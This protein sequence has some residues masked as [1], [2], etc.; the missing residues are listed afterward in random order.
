M[1][2]R[3]ELIAEQLMEANINRQTW[4]DLLKNVRNYDTLQEAFDAAM[5]ANADVG[6]PPGTDYVTTTP[7]VA[8]GI[9]VL[10][11][12]DVLITNYSGNV[13]ATP[14]QLIFEN[15]KV[16]DTGKKRLKNNTEFNLY[17]AVIR[18]HFG[19]QKGQWYVANEGTGIRSYTLSSAAAAGAKTINLSSTTGLLATQLIC[20]L[21]TD[22]EY[23][24][25][26]VDTVSAGSINV[27][28]GLD[29]GIAAGVN[30]WAFYNNFSH[31]NLYGYRTLADFALRS[32][33][34]DGLNEQ[35]VAASFRNLYAR[36]ADLVDAVGTATFATNTSS[37]AVIPGSPIMN[38]LQVNCAASG[39]GFKTKP[40][41]LSGK[42]YKYKIMMNAGSTGSIIITVV[43][44]TGLTIASKTFASGGSYVQF[45]EDTFK[46]R[47]NEEVQVQIIQT[48][49]VS[50][51]QVGYIDIIELGEYK[52]NLNDGTH[53]LLG[54]SWFYDEGIFQRLNERLPNSVII[55]SGIGGNRVEDLI[56]RFDTAVVPYKPDYV[57]IMC[58]TNDYF[59]SVAYYTFAAQMDILLAKI[60][61]IGAKAICFEPSVGVK[62][63]SG[64]ADYQLTD[65]SRNYLFYTE[66]LQKEDG[67]RELTGPY[68]FDTNT[69][70]S[71]LSAG[72]TSN[73]ACFGSFPSGTQ[74]EIEN[75]GGI[76]LSASVYIEV[77]FISTINGGTFDQSIKITSDSNGRL[78]TILTSTAS[79][80]VVVRRQNAS[81]SADTFGGSLRIRVT[82]P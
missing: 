66:Y 49:T 14:E 62:T 58:G 33:R 65:L 53:V 56:N 40:F 48:G 16:D 82:K 74:L 30:L 1:T 60:A 25:A 47:F 55:N 37:N 71:T 54:D 50:F 15:I 44:K 4:G 9:R 11:F 51:M 35:K 39:D 31:P 3:A 68:V 67:I 78:S 2:T 72:A 13:F 69:G 42:S 81:A 19:A 6:F 77:G 64:Y 73:E 27:L 45:V 22:G 57:W 63:Y 38:T 26:Q 43:T 61:D 76:F 28:A 59:G 79:R 8:S 41:K 70:L 24:S 10:G 80:Y 32:L 36:R 75:C 21:G 23:Y 46:S 5:A 29:Q 18:S 34:N 12:G 20:Y 52:D 17:P 7:I